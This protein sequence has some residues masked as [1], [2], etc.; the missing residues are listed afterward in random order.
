MELVEFYEDLLITLE[1]LTNKL[2]SIPLLDLCVS[3]DYQTF[4]INSS[5][6]EKV[7]QKVL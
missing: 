1:T 6:I 4:W 7:F 2:W 5:N 3:L